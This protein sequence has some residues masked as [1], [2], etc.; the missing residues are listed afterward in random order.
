LKPPRRKGGRVRAGI[1][2]FVV[3][4]IMMLAIVAQAQHLIP[5]KIGHTRI[6]PGPLFLLAALSG[7]VALGSLFL[8]IE[9]RITSRR[10]P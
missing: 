1:L 7:A 2:A 6:E 9:K 10:K 3:F 8:E 4:V 5:R